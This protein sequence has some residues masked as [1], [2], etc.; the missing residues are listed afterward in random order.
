MDPEPSHPAPFSRGALLR[1]GLRAGLL[2]GGLALLC[3]AGGGPL[4]AW[5][6]LVLTALALVPATPIEL[7]ALQP[8][9]HPRRMLALIFAS[10]LLSFAALAGGLVQAVYLERRWAVQGGVLDSLGAGLREVGAT[11]VFAVIALPAAILA[12]AVT[13]GL[14]V[15]VLV[16]L[17]ESSAWDDQASRK[18]ALVVQ[19][20]SATALGLAALGSLIQATLVPG[21]LVLGFAGLVAGVCLAAYYVLIDRIAERIEESWELTS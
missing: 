2:G 12:V 15:R 3:L 21:L 11:D 6:A 19:A 13:G 10:A 7:Q 20:L 1:A 18:A 14:L 4:L 16:R 17:L 8:P 9:R 5:N